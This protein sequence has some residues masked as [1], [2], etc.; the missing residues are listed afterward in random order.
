[1]PGH[2]VPIK[3]NIELVPFIIPGNFTIRGK[4]TIIMKC[5]SPGKNVTLHSADIEIKTDKI[6]LVEYE[7][8]K[9]MDISSMELDLER[10]FFVVNLKDKV[11]AGEE[12]NFSLL[13]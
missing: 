8:E 3:Y 10:E 13:T 12:K 9:K 2:L 4:T 11:E 7:S 6:K 1:L 5:V